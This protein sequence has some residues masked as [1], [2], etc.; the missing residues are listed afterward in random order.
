[1]TAEEKEQLR[2]KKRQKVATRRTRAQP[3]ILPTAD[4]PPPL[5]LEAVPEAPVAEAGLPGPSTVPQ[6]PPSQVIDLV[7]GAEAGP[8]GPST[9]SSPSQPS[10][11]IRRGPEM[12]PHL[13]NLCKWAYRAV[14]EAEVDVM[15]K[16]P[17]LSLLNTLGVFGTKASFNTV[18]PQKWLS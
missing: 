14:P 16:S 15:A 2:E 17:A 5:S 3:S 11:T 10:S 1:M 8:S 6:P 9:Q 13:Y 7:E 4:A 18:L 12:P